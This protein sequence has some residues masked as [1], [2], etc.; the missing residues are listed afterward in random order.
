MN[1]VINARVLNERQG[2]PARYTMNVI[3]ELAVIDRT[4]RYLLL[5]YDDLDF[6][7]PLPDNFTV[8]IVRFRSKLFFDYLFIPLFSW[9]NRVDIFLFPKNTFSPLVRGKKIPVYHDIVYFEDFNFREF[10]FFDN[11]H[12]RIMIPV[13]A[14]LS[15]I[16]LTVSDFTA[17][18]MKSLL[19]IR[20]EKIRVVKEGV[21]PHF[22]K[23]SDA[24]K[25]TNTIDKYRLRTPFFFYAGSLSPRKNM[26]NLIRAFIKVK[27]SLPHV[28]YFTG[29]ESWLDTEVHDMITAHGLQDRIIKLGF[30]SEEE[31]VIMYNLAD[32]YLYPS[33]YEGFGLPI[34]EAQACGCPVITS[35][36]S[37]C[38][39]V[40]GNG[41]LYVD[42]H[43]I[44]DMAGAMLKIAKDKKLK[45]SII[46]AGTKNCRRFTW[47]K[48][49]RGILDVFNECSR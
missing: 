10:K 33:L 19:G 5:L 25:L 8:K 35:T 27:D 12:H 42:P 1:I 46:A 43:N 22:R 41:A 44:D 36:V 6:K 4:N 31:L 3:R 30:I 34:L 7:F 47:E 17:S 24:K 2:G 39:E 11:L 26:V 49:A 21:E 45:Q 48:T 16:D 9:F 40:A 28:I 18:R 13:A 23:I 37:S 14:R 20:P 15:K 32:C 29:G 38:P